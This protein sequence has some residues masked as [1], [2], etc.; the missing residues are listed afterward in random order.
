MQWDTSA[1]AGFSTH[2]P[3][4][5]LTHDHKTRNVATMSESKKSILS[6]VRTL[7]RYRREHFS[8]QE[9]TWRSLSTD[10]NVLAYERQKDFDRTIVVLNFSADPQIWSIPEFGRLRVAISTCGDR[11]GEEVG[12]ILHVRSNEGLLIG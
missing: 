2:E 3:W 9:G 1:F 12:S 8:L 10:S 5:P 7:L 11:E 4:L 6:L